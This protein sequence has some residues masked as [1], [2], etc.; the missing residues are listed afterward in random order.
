VVVNVLVL[1][2]I[3]CNFAIFACL[4]HQHRELRK[5]FSFFLQSAPRCMAY[6]DALKRRSRFDNRCHIL[7]TKAGD[8]QAASWK[9]LD[10]SVTR[11]LLHGLA[12]RRAPDP[13]QARQVSLTDRLTRLQLHCYDGVFDELIGPLRQALIARESFGYG[14]F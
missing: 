10:K 14:C 1:P 7:H 11:Q 9:H 2:D 4:A 6:N 8:K 13:E 3:R 12:Y 5:E